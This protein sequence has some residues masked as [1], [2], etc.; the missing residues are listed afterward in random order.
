M[1]DSARSRKEQQQN[2][3]K[4]AKTCKGF[5]VF[6]LT[7]ETAG[8]GP[9]PVKSAI[10]PVFS[11]VLTYLLKSLTTVLTRFIKIAYGDKKYLFKEVL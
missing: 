6:Y 10:I 1:E 8:V 3:K 9:T 5:D 7:M 2:N 11:R 4:N